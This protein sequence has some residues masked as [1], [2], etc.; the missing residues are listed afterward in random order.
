MDSPVA[1][2]FFHLPQYMKTYWSEKRLKCVYKT[3]AT[4]SI[5][6]SML[7]LAPIGLCSTKG[8]I[9][10]RP[11]WSRNRIMYGFSG[12]YTECL[13]CPYR[14]RNAV[15]YIVRSYLWIILART[16]YYIFTAH[17]TIT[18]YSVIVSNYYFMSKWPKGRPFRSYCTITKI[19]ICLWVTNMKKK[20]HVTESNA[21]CRNNLTMEQIHN[22]Q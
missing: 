10:T 12:G 11:T 13:F 8:I 21:R 4:S 16:H 6:F 17:T 2:C 15:L 20:H 5:P 22:L 1:G 7:W 9:I 14:T 19:R 18:Y 3:A